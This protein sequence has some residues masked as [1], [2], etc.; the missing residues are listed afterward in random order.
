M[1]LRLLLYIF[2]FSSH[3]EPGMHSPQFLILASFSGVTPPAPPGHQGH[4][5]ASGART[6]PHTYQVPASCSGCHSTT[7]W[8]AKSAEIYFP[9]SRG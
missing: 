7:D 1:T 5:T 8:V 6:T 3:L 9:R 2:N 4:P